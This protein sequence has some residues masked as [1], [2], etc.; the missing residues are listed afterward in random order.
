MDPT[1]AVVPFTQLLARQDKAL[2]IRCVF[3][4]RITCGNILCLSSPHTLF[5]ALNRSK[6]PLN[7]KRYIQAC[8]FLIFGLHKYIIPPALCNASWAEHTDICLSMFNRTLVSPENSWWPWWLLSE[9]DMVSVQ[10]EHRLEL[11]TG[12]LKSLSWTGITPAVPHL[13]AERLA[14]L[15]TTWDRHRSVSSNNRD[16]P[17]S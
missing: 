9:P 5:Q 2:N 4:Y 12:E 11:Q 13:A 3:C 1:S 10:L 7:P 15:R 14:V 17:A 8:F 6:N 16:L